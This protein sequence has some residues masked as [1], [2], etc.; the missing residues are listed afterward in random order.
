MKKS[1]SIILAFALGAML[2]LQGCFPLREPIEKPVPQKTR[3]LI[4]AAASLEHIFAEELIPM[5]EKTNE[6]ICV[7]GAFDSSGKLQMQIEEGLHADIFMPAAQKQ[8]HALVEQGLVDADSVVDL[9]ENE[10]VLIAPIDSQIPIASFEEIAEAK[11]IALG[12]PKSVPAG[13]YAKEALTRMGVWEAASAKASFG[14]NVT[15]VLN[16]VA[17]GS[18]DVGIVYATDAATSN[19]VKIL[20]VAPADSLQQKVIY[21][22]GIV[23]ASQN[24]EAAQ[25]FMD[26]LQTQEALAVFE[27]YGFQKN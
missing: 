14:T 24:R 25:T 18:A 12:D 7:E 15:E 13:Q 2:V 26:F 27:A 6:R 19:K 1:A 23:A 9:L 21:P 4:A 3:M 10:M 22:A 17:E 20:A 16:W 8:L 11:T 5:F